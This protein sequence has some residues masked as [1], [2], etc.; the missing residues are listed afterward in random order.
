MIRRASARP[1]SDD[2]DILNKF[3]NPD[4]APRYPKATVESTIPTASAKFGLSADGSLLQHRLFTDVR[5]AKIFLRTS[6]V[7]EHDVRKHDVGEHY[8]N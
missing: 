2:P 7:R 4:L 6:F 8:E 5:S 1:E 3:L